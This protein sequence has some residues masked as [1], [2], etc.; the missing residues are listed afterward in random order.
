MWVHRYNAE[1]EH[2]FSQW[3]NGSS[4]CPM[5]VKKSTHTPRAHWWFIWG[6]CS[7]QICSS[8]PNS[9]PALIVGGFTMR[10]EVCCNCPKHWQNQDWVIHYTN[11][12]AHAASSVQQFLAVKNMPMVLTLFTCPI[13][14]LV[15]YSGFHELN[16]NYKRIIS[17]MSLKFKH[18]RQ[19]PYIQFQKVTSKSDR[20]TRPIA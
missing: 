11:V 9:L 7:L 8:R 6:H 15:N 17:I 14:P 19:P 3:K 13:W 4:S 2:Q 20:N 10:Q 12:S 1:S 16:H 18:T 5:R